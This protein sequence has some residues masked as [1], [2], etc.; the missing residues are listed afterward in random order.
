MGQRYCFF[1]RYAR[2][3][4]DLGAVYFGK[5]RG[6]TEK[7]GCVYEEKVVTLLAVRSVR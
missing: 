2:Q 7:W 1:V 6:G 5:G 3:F 4:A